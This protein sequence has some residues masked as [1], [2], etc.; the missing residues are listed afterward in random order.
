MAEPHVISALRDKRAELDGELRQAEKRI[1]QL[2]AD[3]ESIDGTLRVFDP[4]LAP[5]TIRP[6]LRRKPPAHFPR[7]QFSRTVL[8]TL[9]CA[10]DPMTAR[11]IATH[12]ASDYRIDVSATAAMNRLVAKVRQT[13]TSHRGSLASERRGDAIYWRGGLLRARGRS[14]MRGCGRSSPSASDHSGLESEAISGAA[15]PLRSTMT[16]IPDREQHATR[17]G[18]VYHHEFQHNPPCRRIRK[19]N[20]MGFIEILWGMAFLF[21]PTIIGW[22]LFMLNSPTNVKAAIVCFAI[23]P[24][25]LAAM[26]VIYA[27]TT[28]DETPKR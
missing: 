20:R 28:A 3:L 17:K 7:G 21:A 9:R 8:D 23:A 19:N 12:I 22:G 27:A 13:S 6:K 2:R 15:T 5:R 14:K 11:D 18:S 1:I 16:T 26:D 4:S 24:L 25:P 10:S